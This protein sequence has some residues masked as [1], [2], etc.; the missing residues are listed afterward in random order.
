[1]KN[2]L[3]D[4]M[5]IE[6][7][8]NVFT[9]DYKKLNAVYE[10]FVPQ[11]DFS[12]E[13][14]Q[15][16][17]SFISSKNSSNASSPSS[18]SETKPIVAPIPSAN[19]MK[20]D[21]NKMENDFKTFKTWKQY[22][23]LKDLLLEA[24][25]KHEFE[26]CVM[27]SHECV[28][29]NVQDEIEKIQRDAIQTQEGMQKRINILENDVQRSQKQSL[30]FEL[31][32]QHEKERRKCESSLKNVCKT[33]WIS[34]I[35]KLESENVS[36]EFQV[37]SLIKERENVKSEY[38]KLFD[39]IKKTRTQT[40]RKINELIEHVNQKTYAY[41]KVRVQNQD[42]L[43]TISELKAKLK[44]V[45]IDA[46]S[47]RRPS[48]RDSP[49]KI[50]VLSNTKNSSKK[51]EVSVRTTKN[52][53]VASK[54][55]V[56]NQNI[57]TDADVK[58]TF[59]LKDVLCVS[60]AKNV[61]I[62]YHDKC[63]ANY[64]LNVHSKVRRALF[65]TRGTVKSK[66]E[67]TTPVVS[68]TR[69]SVK[70]TQSKSLYTIPVVS[71]TRFS[72]KT[73]QSKSLYTTPVVSKTKIAAVT[74]LSAKNKIIDSGCSKHMIGDCSLLENF[75][76]KFMGTVRFG[77][78]HF[79][80]ITCY[81]DFVQGNITV[82]HVYYVESLG[83]NLFSAG[84]FCDGKEQ[85]IFS[86]TL[87][88]SKY[89]FQVGIASYGFMQTNAETT[90]QR[91]INDDSSVESINTSS[92]EVLDK[93]FGPMYEEYFEKR[94]SEMSINSAAQQVQNH[95]DSPWS[96][97]II[98]EEHEAPPIVTTSEEQI[99]PISLNEADEF[100]Q[101]DFADFD[102]NTV[103]VPCDAPNFKEAESSTTALDPSNMHEFHQVQPLTHIWIK[104]HP[105]E[106]VIGDPSN[107]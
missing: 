2:T 94:S 13:Q 73:T 7:K 59:K 105:L 18:P 15:F 83:H 103:F 19:P 20:L 33:S 38:Q 58:N 32:L 21:L 79:A 50:S 89:S 47:V 1:M 70:T 61:L 36:L 24:K 60:C 67:D 39:S 66:F 76:E 37:Q 54:N 43:I 49:F 6:K 93:F 100:N 63:L 81:G 48:N 5:A 97:S 84:Q 27:L 3:N 8:Q 69:F 107:P 12:A 68:K 64:K 77:N 90:S 17:S 78:D 11:K 62:L 101:E 4:L 28:N 99:Y 16:S 22:E 82:C 45:E 51:V 41:V 30:D 104:A 34:K 72:V 86:S 85:E 56:L 65:T 55:V 71:K 31:Q 87:S 9:I 42:R 10:D 23:L 29:N 53:Y 26:C 96:S 35:E 40:Q 74:P 46:S 57:I 88:G 106:Q 44:N 52:T 92:K 75:V 91:F 80:A 102:G 14:K 95:E 98:F 25:L